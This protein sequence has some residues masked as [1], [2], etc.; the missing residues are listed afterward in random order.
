MT[1]TQSYTPFAKILHWGF[2]VLY[3]YGLLKQLDEVSELEDAGLLVFEVIFA[4]VFLV[5]VVLRYFYMRRFATFLGA[6]VSIS[7]IQQRLARAIH[8]AMYLCLVLLPLSGLLIAG[9]FAQGLK[10]GVMLDFAVGLHGFS[11]SLSYL[12]IAV[13]IAAALY[14]RFKGEGI[15]NAMVPVWKEDLN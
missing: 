3:A 8:V 10:T 9:L 11:A 7:P 12:L 5:I 1:T 15:W 6:H 14:S 13:H 4:S 2:I